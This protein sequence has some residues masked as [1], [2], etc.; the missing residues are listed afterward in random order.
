MP[1]EEVV[2]QEPE[3]LP[4]LTDRDHNIKG[5]PAF[6]FKPQLRT[7]H[8]PTNHEGT[9][10]ADV[11]GIEVLKLFGQRSRSEGPVTADV[12]AP[13]KNHERHELSPACCHGNV[14]SSELDL[15]L[16]PRSRLRLATFVSSGRRRGGAWSQPRPTR[17]LP[18]T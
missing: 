5:E 17:S 2:R 6:D 1:A 4:A 13:E 12:E 11:D 15:S 14:A 10:R 7:A 3:Y 9:C 8:R 18:S 16:R